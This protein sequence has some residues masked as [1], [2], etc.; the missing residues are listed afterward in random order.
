MTVTDTA[1]LSKEKSLSRTFSISEKIFDNFAR[2]AKC[3]DCKELNLNE[4]A[5]SKLFSIFT[6]DVE[7]SKGTVGVK[8]SEEFRSETEKHLINFKD[9]PVVNVNNNMARVPI[10]YS[11]NNNTTRNDNN[12]NR[13]NGNFNNYNN[14]YQHGKKNWQDNGRKKNTGNNNYNGSGNGNGNYNNNIKNSQTIKTVP[15]EKKINTPLNSTNLANVTNV[16]G[17]KN[18]ENISENS[19]IIIKQ[20]DIE[21]LF[22]DKPIVNRNTHNQD[23]L[24][25]TTTSNTT[26]EVIQIPTNNNNNYYNNNLSR[27]KSYH[28]N[29]NKN[30]N[31]YYEDDMYSNEYQDNTNGNFYMSKKNNQNRTNG[32]VY[33]NGNYS[34]NNYNNGGKTTYNKRKKY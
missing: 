18:K 16:N 34:S 22:E 14:N 7:D 28:N 33:E 15:E 3:I 11:R 9:I 2:Y 8:I 26:I 1:I 21:E 13:D 29:N 4:K 10:D 17:R 5:P 31:N 32:S 23:H 25:V 19:K 6:S 27:K 24:K 30:N 20:Q 12:N